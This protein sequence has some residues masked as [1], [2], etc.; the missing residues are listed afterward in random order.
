MDIVEQVLA[1]PRGRR[2][3]AHLG[4]ACSTD[5]RASNYLEPL[6]Q[7][8]ALDVLAAVDA[9]TVA[10]LSELD[11]LEA[12]GRATDFARYWQPPDEED[13]W[14]A[15]P[16]IVT[17]SSPIVEAVLACAHARWWSTPMDP[18]CQRAVQKRYT[19]TDEWSETFW[20][21]QDHDADL[22]AWRRHVLADEDRFRRFLD[23]DPERQISG[24]W[25]STPVPSRVRVTSRARQNL[26]AVELLLAEDDNSDGRHARVW[27]VHVDDAARIY[28]ITGSAAW[29][30]LVDAYPLPV[31]ASRRS[32]W[33]EATGKHLQW[34][35]P[36]WAAVSADYDAVHLTALG[37]LTTPGLALP[38][39]THTGASVLAGWDPD[40]TFWLDP[41]LVR[42]FGRPVEWHRTGDTPWAPAPVR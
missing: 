37:Y 42:T 6:T 15:D 2:F 24:E 41:R 14:F 5:E 23:A 34:Y 28:E 39:T 38:L 22:P 32:D 11:V 25:W 40:A 1:A 20:N 16:A 19:S 29:T 18:T 26:G 36:D 27:S 3:A 31:A 9:E 10:Q 17:A 8:D 21:N 35:L 30:H 13:L 7:A 33:Y 12:L 4:Y